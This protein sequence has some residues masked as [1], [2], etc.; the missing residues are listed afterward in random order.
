MCVFCKFC[1]YLC[2]F[3]HVNNVVEGKLKAHL[4]TWWTLQMA[5]FSDISLVH[6]S[7]LPFYEYYFHVAHLYVATLKLFHWQFVLTFCYQSTRCLLHGRRRVDLLS[8]ARCSPVKC[9]LRM[10]KGL[11]QRQDF[12]LRAIAYYLKE[13][14]RVLVHESHGELKQ[15]WI[16]NWRYLYFLASWGWRFTRC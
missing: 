7:S 9:Q 10:R 13:Y 6:S 2:L 12:P 3:V 1:T 5:T 14:L 8:G 16:R 11:R 4:K 15:D